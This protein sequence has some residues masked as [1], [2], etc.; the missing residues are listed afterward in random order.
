MSGSYTPEFVEGL[1]IPLLRKGLEWAEAEAAR[2][3]QEMSEWYQ[4]GVIMDAAQVGRSC[5]TCYCLAGYIAVQVDPSA[6]WDSAIP[7]A[8]NALGLKF[9]ELGGLFVGDNSIEKLRSIAESLAGE[10]L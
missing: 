5:G 7:I 6:S 2:P 3:D 1:N 8:V 10:K 4:D 9:G